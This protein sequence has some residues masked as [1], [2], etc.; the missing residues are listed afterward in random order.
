MMFIL[1]ILLF[2]SL[3]MMPQFLQ[4]QLGYTAQLA[5]LVLSGG[6]LVMLIAMPIVG[7]LTTRVQARYLVAF[8]WFCLAGATYYSTIRIDLLVSFSSATWLS[9]AQRAGLAF[10]FVPISLVAYSGVPTEQE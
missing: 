1:G 4:T 9:V 3:V 6:A 5:G 10:L 7:Q 2:S 8:G